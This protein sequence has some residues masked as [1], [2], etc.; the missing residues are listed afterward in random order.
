MRIY[1]IDYIQ[2]G[3]LGMMARPRGND[4]LEDEIKKLKLADVKM[5]VSLLEEHEEAELQLTEEQEFC[6][7]YDIEFVNFPIIDRGV[8][9]DP[10]AYLQLISR[11]EQ[12]LENKKVA[13]HCRMGIGRTSVI[14][15]GVLLKSGYGRDGVFEYLSS[16]RTL[17][18]PDTKEQEEWV[19]RQL[20]M[21]Q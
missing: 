5:V 11:I 2:N 10:E 19:L 4:W 15:A 16:V 21:F 6:K 1:W 9:A 14:A 13:I 18:V 17:T 7:Q 3:A 20:G 12:Q 8:P